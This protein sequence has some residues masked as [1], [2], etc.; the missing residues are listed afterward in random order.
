MG[1][2]E[3]KDPVKPSGSSV[4]QNTKQLAW[5]PSFHHSLSVDFHCYIL[6]LALLLF[7]K[8]FEHAESALTND[9]DSKASQHI[10]H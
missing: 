3:N 1:G 5:L 7:R 10:K 8:T 4:M 2:S 9:T 6:F